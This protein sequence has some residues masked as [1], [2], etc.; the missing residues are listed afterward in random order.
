VR[1]PEDLVFAEGVLDALDHSSPHAL[2]GG[3]LGLDATRKLPGEPGAGDPLPAGAPRQLAAPAALEAALAP[4]FPGLRACRIPVPEARL[5]LALLVFEKSRPGEGADMARAAVD[6]GV[7]VAVAVEGTQ[8]D[9][10]PLLAWRAFSSV[11]PLRDVKVVG[12]R[13]AVDASVK[14]P[15]EGHPR[16]WPAELSHPPEVRARAEAV[17]RELGLT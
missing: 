12:R 6:L 2:W 8:A 10:L 15:A 5:L 17:A 11:D 3:K 4:R 14:G 16:G 7:D 9:P 1:I 13:V